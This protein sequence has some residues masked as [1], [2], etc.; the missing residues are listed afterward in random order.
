MPATTENEKTTPQQQ[1]RKSPVGVDWESA[2]TPTAWCGALTWNLKPGLHV[3]RH[4]DDLRRLD[5]E[6]DRAA[7]ELAKSAGGDYEIQKKL[8]AHTADILGK[9]LEN[10]DY[11]KAAD[12]VEAGPAL[13]TQLSAEVRGFLYIGGTRGMRLLKTRL[14]TARRSS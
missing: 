11:E 10:F 8:D 4:I 5:A 7:R 14:D 13:L 6:Y 2:D 12:D 1:Q 3:R 9:T